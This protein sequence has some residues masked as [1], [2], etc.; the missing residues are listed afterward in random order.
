MITATESAGRQLLGGTPVPHGK[1][2]KEKRPKTEL[3]AD[4]DKFPD[5]RDVTLMALSI[6]GKFGLRARTWR[7]TLKGE[8]ADADA[9]KGAVEAAEIELLELARR[10]GDSTK[11]FTRVSLTLDGLWFYAPSWFTIVIDTDDW[12]FCYKGDFKNYDQ[13]M[14]YGQKDRIVGNAT[15]PDEKDENHSFFNAEADTIRAGR[16]PARNA[17]RCRNYFKMPNEDGADLDRISPF[18]F[19]IF[20]HIPLERLIGAENRA[21]IIIDPTGENRGPK[22]LIEPA[23]EAEA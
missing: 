22:P 8:F 10:D 6:T 19:N 9:L 16:D 18:G 21:V 4:K 11:D 20:L 17:V 5:P 13:F 14:F 12:D 7:T 1:S 23:P 2:I 3:Q 15:I